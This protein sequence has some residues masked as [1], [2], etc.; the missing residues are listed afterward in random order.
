[1]N[2][3]PFDKRSLLGCRTLRSSLWHSCIRRR[4]SFHAIYKLSL[5]Y[6]TKLRSHCVIWHHD[7]P[8]LEGGWRFLTNWVKTEQICRMLQRH[9]RNIQVINLCTCALEYMQMVLNPLQQIAAYIFITLSHRKIVNLGAGSSNL[10][11]LDWLSPSW[12]WVTD[13]W[14]PPHAGPTCQWPKVREG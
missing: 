12:L 11:H 2:I 5:S 14:V 10:A 8:W 6:D 7:K 4:C 1:M 3:F 9:C 13:M